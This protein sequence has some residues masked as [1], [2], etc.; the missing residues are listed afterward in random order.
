MEGCATRPVHRPMK[1]TG[2]TRPSCF[3]GLAAT[4][5]VALAVPIAAQTPIVLGGGP[6]DVVELYW[7]LGVRGELLTPEGWKRSSGN[8]KP[9][10]PLPQDGSF[11]VFSNDYGI[12]AARVT[13]DTAIVQVGFMNVGRIDALL[14]YNGPLPVPSAVL[15]TAFLFRLAITP[16]YNVMY[17][18]DGKTIIEKKQ[19]GNSAWTITE[20]K[21]KPWTTVNTA[22]RH[23]LEMRNKTADPVIKKNADETLAKLLTL[24]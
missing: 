6:R 4:L 9:P 1:R 23:V 17:G 8:F 11:D 20:P 3:L 5:A 19:T 16:V 24:H 22:I 12:D 13:A 14:R 2:T 18:P 7:N 10:N 21:L 15:E